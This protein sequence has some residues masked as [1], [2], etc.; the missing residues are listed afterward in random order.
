LHRTG[1][2]TFD[3]A[4]C[5][6]K[7]N[8]IRV[9]TSRADNS[10]YLNALNDADRKRLVEI[11]FNQVAAR[12][13]VIMAAVIDKRHLREHMTPETLHKKAY[14]FLLERIEH[15]MAEFHPKHN[16]L[17]VMDDTSRQLN[18]AVAMKHAYFQRAGNQN[19]QFR[20]VVEYPFFTRSE[21]SNGVQLADLLAYN[22]YRA[23]KDENFDYAYFQMM[24]GNFYRRGA[25]E[26]L[27]GLKVW[28]EGSPLIEMARAAWKNYRT[29]HPEAT[30]ED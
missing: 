22:V 23:F 11:F 27:D 8:W 13:A 30:G 21:L 15:Y 12:K 17:I 5:E 4:A 2:G 26:I 20:H 29:R 6:V 9:P 1:K 25:G 14:E 19:M 24:L 7:S 18:R 10:P 28:P 3:L 16:A